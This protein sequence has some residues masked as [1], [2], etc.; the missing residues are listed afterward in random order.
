MLAPASAC[1]AHHL[2]K[3]PAQL[4]HSQA[5]SPAVPACFA[6]LSII[7]Q[8][9]LQRRAPS[10]AAFFAASASSCSHALQT[11][12]PTVSYLLMLRPSLQTCAIAA[13]LLRLTM[14]IG[15][16]CSHA[17]TSF[18][19]PDST[20]LLLPSSSLQACAIVGGMLR[21]VGLVIFFV[22]MH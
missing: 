2:S 21:L 6:T 13:G 17:V 14:K 16:S 20:C 22:F 5:C 11:A 4:M 8:I 1:L 12:V 19:A 15:L 10:A 3:S 18:A 7:L 9:A